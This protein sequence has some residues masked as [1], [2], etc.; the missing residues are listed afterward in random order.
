MFHGAGVPI[1]IGSDAHRPEDV[2]QGFDAATR[3]AS[4]VGY[5]SALEFTGRQGSVVPL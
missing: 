2:G 4:D 3:L 5:D 1:T